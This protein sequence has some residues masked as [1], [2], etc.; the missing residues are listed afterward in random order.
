M[1]VYIYVLFQS[2]GISFT[3]TATVLAINDIFYFDVDFF[4]K[5]IA[6]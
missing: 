6:D 1:K 5:D 2:S 3:V 4:H